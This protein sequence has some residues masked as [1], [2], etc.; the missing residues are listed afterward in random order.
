MLRDP[1]DLKQP[2]EDQLPGPHPH[3]KCEDAQVPLCE[4]A[5]HLHI[6]CMHSPGFFLF[7][8]A[9]SHIA[10]APCVLHI[11]EDDLELLIFLLRPGPGGFID[12]CMCSAGVHHSACM[13][14]RYSTVTELHSQLLHNTNTGKYN[15]NSCS[16]MVREGRGGRTP[17]HIHFGVCSPPPPPQYFQCKVGSTDGGPVA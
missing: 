15:S 3:P 8:K 13:L 1:L 7:F 11:A 5:Q 2:K 14:S 12:V 6:I 4:K 17:I 10:Q 16:A 9:G